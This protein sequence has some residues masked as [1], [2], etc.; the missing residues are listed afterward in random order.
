M[1]LLSVL[2]SREMQDNRHK[3]GEL[4]YGGAAAW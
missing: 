2:L 3:G 1:Q 4:L